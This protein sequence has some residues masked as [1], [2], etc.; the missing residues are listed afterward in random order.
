MNKEKVS[1]LKRLTRREKKLKEKKKQN[2]LI[3]KQNIENKK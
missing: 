1:N 3:D 2:K